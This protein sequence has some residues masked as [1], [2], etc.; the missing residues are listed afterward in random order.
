MIENHI[1]MGIL[2]RFRER[3]STSLTALGFTS[4]S[5]KAEMGVE[6]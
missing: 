2:P 4:I 6:L 1:N 5:Q 3:V